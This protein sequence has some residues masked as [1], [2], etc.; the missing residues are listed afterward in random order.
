LHTRPY[1]LLEPESRTGFIHHFLALVRYLAG[2]HGDV[3]HVRLPG[4]LI[5]REIDER[6]EVSDEDFDPPQSVM[7]RK[8]KEAWMDENAID[9]EL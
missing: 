2:G 3:G 5:H 4:Q 9:C 7:T 6:G 8:E 1:S